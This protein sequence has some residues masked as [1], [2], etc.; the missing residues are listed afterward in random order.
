MPSWGRELLLIKMGNRPRG[1]ILGVEEDLPI[2]VHCCSVSKLCPT[3]CDPYTTACQ[4]SLTFTISRSLLK[5]RS[6]I[7]EAQ[8]GLFWPILK[9]GWRWVSSN[10]PMGPSLP[11]ASDSRGGAAGGC[12]Y[13]SSHFRAQTYQFLLR[14]PWSEFLLHSPWLSWPLT[15]LWALI[16]L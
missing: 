5:L 4:I 11:G 16:S 12:V 6:I 15:N 10:W 1:D 14:W 2:I 13:L 3:L 8:S 7:K 9:D